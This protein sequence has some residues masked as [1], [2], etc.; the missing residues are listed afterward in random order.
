MKLRTRL[1]IPVLLAAA[2]MLAAAPAGANG[3]RKHDGHSSKHYGNHGGKHHG[4]HYGTYSGGHHYKAKYHRKHHKHHYKKHYR[5]HHGHGH[6]GR[7]Y[8]HGHY[9][10]RH[11]YGY[12]VHHYGHGG[13]AYYCGPCSH[14][15]DSYDHLSSHV[16]HHHGIAVLALP[17]VIFQA[18]FGAGVGWVFGY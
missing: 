7:S 5:K 1:S 11:A 17:T 3:W 16:H 6:H 18:S 10:D 15:F 9:V 2:L 14:Y 8:G 13:S 12:P 4:K